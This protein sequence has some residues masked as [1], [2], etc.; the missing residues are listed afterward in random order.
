YD[1]AAMYRTIE[2]LLGVPPMN[3]YDGHA[4]AMYDVFTAEPDY[5]PYTFVPRKVPLATNSVDAPMA[6]E[7][8]R[9]DFTRPDQAPL[10][11]I[12]WKAVKGRDAEPPWGAML[13]AP[14]RDTDGD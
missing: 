4:A 11:R 6:A 7:S 10:G 8:S 5:T 3:L 13:E 2:L 14:Y 12:L 1:V 9:I